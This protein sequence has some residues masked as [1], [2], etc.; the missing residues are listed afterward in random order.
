MLDSEYRPEEDDLLAEILSMDGPN[1]VDIGNFRELRLESFTDTDI[2]ELLSQ[3]DDPTR[4]ETS[5]MAIRQTRGSQVANYPS[6]D[7]H[8]SSF[9]DNGSFAGEESRTMGRHSSGVLPPAMPG[10]GRLSRPNSVPS[11]NTLAGGGSTHTVPAKGGHW[12]WIPDPGSDGAPPGPPP[13]HTPG[14]S[15]GSVPIKT[16]RLP[17][18]MSLNQP[19]DMGVYDRDIIDSFDILEMADTLIFEN[20]AKQ[21]GKHAN[22]KRLTTNSCPVASLFQEDPSEL[23][24]AV[25]HSGH[26]S[27]REARYS[28]REIH[29]SS[30]VRSRPSSAAIPMTMTRSTSSKVNR[31]SR[32]QSSPHTSNIL[33]ASCPSHRVGSYGGSYGV[34]QSL[35]D[36]KDSIS[37]EKLSDAL[38]P[39]YEY[40]ALTPSYSSRSLDAAGTKKK[41]NPWTVAETMSLISGVEELGV[42]KWADIKRSPEYEQVFM[43]R[44]AVDLKDKWRNLTRLAKLPVSKLEEKVAKDTSRVGDSIPLESYLQVRR[45]AGIS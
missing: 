39:D 35:L 21:N 41:H 26:L 17:L 22:E 15:R 44:S 31:C 24:G 43:A 28:S 42:S 25:N 1:Q 6:F 13:L 10:S 27:V 4:E 38:D 3:I 29:S 37:E 2:P 9:L 30:R 32:S 23:S 14:Q 45:I 34:S 33:A 18:A 36:S 7:S 16:G 20:G 5:A 8:T 40:S 11:L 12:A 19:H